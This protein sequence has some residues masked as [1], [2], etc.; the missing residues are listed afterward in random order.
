MDGTGAW[1]P[2]AGIPG[3]PV[4]LDTMDAGVTV[5]TE[6]SGEIQPTTSP[7]TIY[8]DWRHDWATDIGSAYVDDWALEEAGLHVDAWEIY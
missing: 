5:W 7:V 8:A 4:E 6:L 1:S 2:N 3:S